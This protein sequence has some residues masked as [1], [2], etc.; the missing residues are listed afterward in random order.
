MMILD[1]DE[2][3]VKAL[4]AG[5]LRR[6]VMFAL[7]IAA[8]VVLLVATVHADELEC[9]EIEPV[10]VTQLFEW[11]RKA[12]DA[13]TVPVSEDWLAGFGVGFNVCASAVRTVERARFCP[14][15]EE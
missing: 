2:N 9:R 15:E 6:G 13:L 4:D 10:F 5:W 7:F 12:L 14:A 1:R 11:E 8:I 3:D